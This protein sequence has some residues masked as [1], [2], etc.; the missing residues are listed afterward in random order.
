MMEQR[1]EEWFAARLGCVTA[2]RVADVMAKTAKG[3]GA[4]RANYMA[5]LIAERLTG[6]RQE[7]YTSA[8]MQHGNDTE[9]EARAAYSFYCNEQVVEAPF[10]PHPSIAESGASPDGFVGE[11]GL[12]ELKCPNTATHLDTLESE[13]VPT[14]YI[15]Q[16]QWQ[17]ACTGRKWVDFAS[18]DPRL[19]EAMR[20]FVKRV[21][22]DDEMIAEMESAVTD[23][24][25]EVRKR[26]ENMQRKFDLEPPANTETP[27][28]MA[29]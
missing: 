19:P 5:Q 12:L 26:V 13:K 24:L 17:L 18:Y 1:S 9:A 29:G 3:W 7:T 20:L 14:K 6:E 8:A 16:M 15:K 10:V 27:Y 4:S 2:S 25:T 28:L 23:F 21:E 22:R 11:E